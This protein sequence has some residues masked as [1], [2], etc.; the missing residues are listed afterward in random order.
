MLYMLCDRADLVESDYLQSLFT[1]G[2]HVWC[3]Q[4]H[5][6]SQDCRER[7]VWCAYIRCVQTASRLSCCI[8]WLEVQ[9]LLPAMLLRRLPALLQPRR[10]SL[11]GCICSP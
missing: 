5:F 11:T 1:C 3:L 8:F 9:P 4:L 10:S 7:A 6:V 2:T